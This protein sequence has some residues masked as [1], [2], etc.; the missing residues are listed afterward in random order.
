M[1]DIV[2]IGLICVTSWMLAGFAGLFV[3]QLV[4]KTE[5]CPAT[6]WETKKAFGSIELQ[7]EI[8]AMLAENDDGCITPLRMRK[9]LHDLNRRGD[10]LTDLSI[11][12][13]LPDELA[14]SATALRDILT[15][16]NK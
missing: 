6:G 2:K 16:L 15:H 8:D 5:K 11:D 4:N 3:G 13:R 7:M 10:A 9:V 12:S 14:P 1:R